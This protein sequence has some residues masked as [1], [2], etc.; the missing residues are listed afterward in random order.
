MHFNL[1]K[2]IEGV[3]EEKKTLETTLLRAEN[4]KDKSSHLNDTSMS[5]TSRRKTGHRSQSDIR[6]IK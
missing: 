2:L 5:S 4:D 1:Q 3:E 6:R